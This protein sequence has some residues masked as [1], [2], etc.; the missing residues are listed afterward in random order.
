MT[1]RCTYDDSFRLCREVDPTDA[2]HVAIALE[3]DG[4]LWTGDEQLKDELREQGF[5]TFTIPNRRHAEAS[6]VAKTPEGR[7]PSAAA[8]ASPRR[9]GPP[10]AWRTAPAGPP[11]PPA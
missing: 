2:P 4:L 11:P 7:P 6:V 8:S 5:V 3:I 9:P 1:A 10:A